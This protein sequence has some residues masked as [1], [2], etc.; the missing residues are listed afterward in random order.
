MS[1]P[2]GKSALEIARQTYLDEVINKTI[3]HCIDNNILSEFLK[4]NRDAVTSALEMEFFMEI[5]N[6]VADER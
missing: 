2:D 6:R 1:T 4:E 5:A 3:D